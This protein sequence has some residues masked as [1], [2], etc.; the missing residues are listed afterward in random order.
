[1]KINSYNTKEFLEFSKYSNQNVIKKYLFKYEEDGNSEFPIHLIKKESISFKRNIFAIATPIL[2]CGPARPDF[3]K[4][5][6]NNLDEGIS[7]GFI[8]SRVEKSDLETNGD[9]QFYYY[10]IQERNNYRLDLE[11][12]SKGY[13]ET[14][15]RDSKQRYKQ[16]YKMNHKYNL[17]ENSNCNKSIELFAELYTYN[18]MVNNF[19]KTYI[20]NNESWIKL[21]SSDSWKLY[22]LFY[23]NKLVAA[24]VLA[25]VDNSYDYSFMAFN[26]DHK[27]ASRALIFFLRNHFNEIGAS[28]YLYLGGGISETDSLADFKKSVGGKAVPFTRIKF[29]NKKIFNIEW[30]VAEK[31]LKGRWP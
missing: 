10:V 24:C 17:I 8:Q 5:V 18:S 7:S 15:K 4:K 12:D 19:P 28:K 29:M 22:S 3:L 1:M 27:D 23:E 26:T 2:F 20:F 21:L 30:E 6:L 16:I 13:F 31:L 9:N 25:Q 11:N 14:L